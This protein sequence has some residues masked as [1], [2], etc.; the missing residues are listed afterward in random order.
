MS[1]ATNSPAAVARSSLRTLLRDAA[2]LDRTQ[3]DPLVSLRNAIGIAGPLAWATLA[4]NAAIGLASTVGAIQ[5]GFADRPGPYRLRMLRMFGTAVVAA[6]TSALAVAASR[7]DAASTVLLLVLAFGAGLLVTAGASATQV[8]TAAV[9]A[10]LLLGHVPSSPSVARARRAAGAGRGRG[11][12]RAR[13]SPAGRCAGTGRS[14]RPWPPCTA[15]SP[16]RPG[17]PAAPGPAAGGR[18]ADRGASDVLRSRPRPRPERGGVPGAAG[19]GGADP[20]R[21]RGRRGRPRNG[22]AGDGNPI[23]AGL[24]RAAVGAAGGVLDEIA[25]ALARARPIDESVLDQPREQLRAH[26]RATG[27]RHGRTG[28]THPPGRGRAGCARC[29]GSC[30]PRSRAPAP[31]R[32]RAPAA[33]P[34]APSAGELLRDPIAILRANLTPDSAI[35][36]HA[37]RVAVLVAGSDLV[38]RLAGF[39]RG[40]WVPLTVLVVLRP[41]FAA[42]L[43]RSVLRTVGTVAGLLA[44]TALVHWTPGGDWWQVS[45]VVRVR[46]R[47]AAG[48]AGNVGA[49]GG[50]PVRA[51]RDPARDPGHLG[52]DDAARPRA[53][54]RGRRG[55]RASSPP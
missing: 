45:L 8:G 21:D 1:A 47:D 3:S 7:T 16:P 15:S 23:L 32:A 52:A 41:D 27:R 42:T 51:R 38:V 17:C 50:E 36:R 25:D 24:V 33:I 55:A 14:G 31:G 48:R 44:A 40:Y 28:R 12:G 20:P 2:R 39:D 30:G 5:T 37:V 9:A 4:G 46:V 53:R 6:A 54:H 19:R 11:A 29:P 34:A 35:V 43:Q 26:D 10:A 49:V 22:S 18:H 13:P